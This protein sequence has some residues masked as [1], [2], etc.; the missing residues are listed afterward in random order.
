LPT[1]RVLHLPNP[2]NPQ[3]P[4]AT[5]AGEQI[6]PLFEKRFAPA[7][8]GYLPGRPWALYPVR[9]IRRKNVLEAALGTRLFPGGANLLTTLPGHSDQER[10]YSDLTE[11]LY[12]DGTIPGLWGTGAWRDPGAPDFEEFTQAGDLVF[13]ASLQEGFGYFF[14]DSFRW[15]KPLFSR[16]L[17]ILDEL[18]PHLPPDRIRL[19][20]RLWVPPE[21]EWI[22]RW[23]SHW[24]RQ[25]REM[26]DLLGSWNPLKSESN[27]FLTARGFDF[28]ALPPDDQ[29][30]VLRRAAGDPAFLQDIAERNADFVRG[31]GEILEKSGTA[32]SREDLTSI[33]EQWGLDAFRRRTAALI[34]TAAENGLSP[35]S[36]GREQAVLAAFL[37]AGG[38]RP[39]FTPYPRNN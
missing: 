18:L 33:G 20:D 24:E 34:R 6:K 9:T 32:G 13:S 4:R 22:R 25:N 39:L 2:V 23:E 37:N 28:S 26:E 35:C 27:P 12:R 16:R 5:K 36:E 29:A 8:P 15:G 31:A 17:D 10:G 30:T 11:E 38:L 7:F 21:K 19:Y 1:E 14:I 3:V